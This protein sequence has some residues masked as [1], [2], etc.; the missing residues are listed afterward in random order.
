MA[1]IHLT[2]PINVVTEL[3]HVVSA[4]VTRPSLFSVTGSADSAG[5]VSSLVSRSAI[6]GR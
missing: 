3:T 4:A 5:V 6:Y 2:V 1:L